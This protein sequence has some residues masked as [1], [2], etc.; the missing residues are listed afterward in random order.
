MIGFKKVPAKAILIIFIICISLILLLY[1]DV[2]TDKSLPLEKIEVSEELVNK[3]PKTFSYKL[4]EVR[5]GENLSIIFE[6]FEA[7]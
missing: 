1:A 3:L 7:M 2:T 5:D 4:H 6:D